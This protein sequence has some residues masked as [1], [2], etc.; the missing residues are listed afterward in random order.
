[1]AS[2]EQDELEY[3]LT[4]HD[5]WSM[6]SEKYRKRFQY[7]IHGSIDDL[8]EEDPAYPEAWGEKLDSIPLRIAEYRKLSPKELAGKWRENIE[9]CLLLCCDVIKSCEDTPL[10]AKQRGV[11]WIDAE[12][13][14]DQC[15]ELWNAIVDKISEAAYLADLCDATEREFNYLDALL[16]KTHNP[17]RD[18]FDTLDGS[19]CLGCQAVLLV[20][21]ELLTFAQRSCNW[22][23]IK[24]VLNLSVWLADKSGNMFEQWRG[25]IER[26]WLELEQI[27]P[28][29][30]SDT[31]SITTISAKAT[32]T[33]KPKP[34]TTWQSIATTLLE[35]KRKGIVFA[36]Q[37]KYKLSHRW[38]QS[39]VCKAIAKTPELHA[40]A[41]P[42]GKK[43]DKAT[44]Q[45]GEIEL[46]NTPQSR[47]ERPDRMITSDDIEK[48][49]AEIHE[50]AADKPELLAMYRAY[51]KKQMR[52]MAVTAIKSGLEILR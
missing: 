14:H 41:R 1:M 50:A 35:M 3:V 9:L 20:A 23:A 25:A 32:S 51:P 7:S 37:D 30:E 49:I 29:P 42:T 24:S 27:L 11:G 46:D 52:S 19:S 8:R 17:K 10:D 33:D 48:K 16:R 31:I 44:T 5:Y 39:T 36:G 38:N 34:K 40:W 21:D 4:H 43:N 45:L 26:E 13:L 2:I 6:L 47:E 12:W 22:N 28:D 15:D 18:D